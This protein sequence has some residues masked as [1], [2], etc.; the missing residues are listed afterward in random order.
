MN[1]IGI[2]RIFCNVNENIQKE[3]YDWLVGINRIFCNVNNFKVYE[4]GVTTK[5]LIEYFV[6]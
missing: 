4:L 6:M 5:V 1:Y 3:W 2:N